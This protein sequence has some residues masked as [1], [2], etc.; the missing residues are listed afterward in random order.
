MKQFL[1][2]NPT[3]STPASVSLLIQRLVFGL[4]MLIGH[5]WGKLTNFSAI[6]ERFMDFMGLGTTVSLA[7]AVFAEVICAFL[8]AV[9]LFT[10]AALIPLIITMT[11][12]AFIAHGNDPFFAAPREASKEMALLFLAGYL[13]I[14]VAGPGKFSLDRLLK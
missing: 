9:G 5:G 2:S 8:V 4:F 12:A 7:L 13:S 1:F 11:V 6:S 3:H 14:F 10:R